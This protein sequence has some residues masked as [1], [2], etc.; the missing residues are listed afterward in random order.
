MKAWGLKV[1]FNPSTKLWSWPCHKPY[2]W[3]VQQEQAEKLN[4]VTNHQATDKQRINITQHQANSEFT[5]AKCSFNLA[6]L[7]PS[8]HCM[9]N[10]L[11]NH[12]LSL[13][14]DNYLMFKAWF[15]F[16]F[17]FVFDAAIIWGDSTVQLSIIFTLDGT[18]KIIIKK[19]PQIKLTNET[20]IKQC[21]CLVEILMCLF[22]S[23]LSFF[24]FFSVIYCK[25]Q[26]IL[27]VGDLHNL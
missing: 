6:V 13:T 8:V 18:L 20:L 21:Y 26:M 10:V 15:F 11:C 23:L 4:K 14:I 16:F 12:Q 5:T 2:H 19:P 22:P 9:W 27:D 1:Q 17:L 7:V 24:I 3:C 25:I